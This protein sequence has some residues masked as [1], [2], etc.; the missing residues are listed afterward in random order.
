MT[1][2][3]RELAALTWAG[4]EGMLRQHPIGLLPVGAI[5]AHGPH[6]PFDTDVI[7]ATEMARGAARLLDRDGLATLLLPPLTYGVSFVGTC[8]GGTSPVDPSA[9]EAHLYSL[10]TNMLPQG[11]RAI[12]ICNA[13]LEPAHVEAVRAAAGRAAETT[14]VPVV[15]PDKRE[16]RWAARLSEEFRRGAR[17]A[18]SYETALVMAARPDAVRRDELE[19]LPPV[20]VDLPARLR[21]GARSF[22]E[23]G[24]TRGYFGDPARA[25][26][27]EGEML[28]AALAAMVRDAV[29]EVLAGT[30]GEGVK[31]GE[32]R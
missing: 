28:F 16:A 19:S 9:F 32:V 26:V 14:G 11:Y 21:A 15:F 31:G 22:A 12:V 4:A 13:H 10:L 29:L 8:F 2:P 3:V 5:E 24:G 27:D 23:A 1:D 25:S 18:G 7:I 20:W 6:L 30:G 17:H